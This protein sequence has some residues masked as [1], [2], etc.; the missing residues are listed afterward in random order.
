MD[1]QLQVESTFIYGISFYLYYIK[2]LIALRLCAL[3]EMNIWIFVIVLIL[4]SAFPIYCFVL[5]AWV[6]K[7]T[8]IYKKQTYFLIP[9]RA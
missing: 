3:W 9:F 1:W 8:Y 6:C 7:F 5:Q 2:A 4:G